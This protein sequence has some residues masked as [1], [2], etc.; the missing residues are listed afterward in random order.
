MPIRLSSSSTGPPTTGSGWSR[1]ERA[2]WLTRSA[3]LL[4]GPPQYQLR[5]G[6]EVWL[7]PP[8]EPGYRAPH[9]YKT[10]TVNFL[11]L[12]PAY[13]ASTLVLSPAVVGLH[14]FMVAGVST[15]FSILVG[16]LVVM[17]HIAPLFRAWLYPPV[18]AC[19]AG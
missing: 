19:P 14:P 15:A 17:P 12:Y 13:V 18:T 11:A 9:L 16:G 8:D 1:P 5:S 4:D 6:L 10:L 7:T 3:P 2:A